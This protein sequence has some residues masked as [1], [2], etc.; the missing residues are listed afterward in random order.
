MAKEELLYRR[1]LMQELVRKIREGLS[2]SHKKHVENPECYGFPEVFFLYEH[3]IRAYMEYKSSCGVRVSR[4][5][6]KMRR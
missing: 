5:G 4:E 1:G 2:V 6:M 3:V